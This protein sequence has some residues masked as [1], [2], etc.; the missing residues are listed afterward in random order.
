MRC[1]SLAT[2]AQSAGHDVVFVTVDVEGALH[3]YRRLV[4]AGM[5]VLAP[6]GILVAASCSSRVPADQFFELVIDV[7]MDSAS[8]YNVL[9]ESQHALDHPIGFSEGAYLKCIVLQI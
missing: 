6:A 9:R 3:A 2:A 7:V 1:L 5:G 8:H 4:S